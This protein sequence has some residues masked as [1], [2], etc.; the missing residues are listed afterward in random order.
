VRYVEHRSREQQILD[1]ARLGLCRCGTPR[2]ADVVMGVEV[3][4][5]PAMGDLGVHDDPEPVDSL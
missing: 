3:A 2:V 5:C 1:N 4:R